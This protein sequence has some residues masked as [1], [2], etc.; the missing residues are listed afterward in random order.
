[1]PESLLWNGDVTAFLDAL[2]EE[3][4]FDLAFTSPPYNIGKAYE[5]QQEMEHYLSWQEEVMVE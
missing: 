2:L 1:M 4:I 3:P 5:M